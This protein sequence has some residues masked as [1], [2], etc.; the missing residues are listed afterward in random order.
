MSQKHPWER[1]FHILS[2]PVDTCRDYLLNKQ[3][4]REE[5]GGERK[6]EKTERE[7]EGVRERGGRGE[8]KIEREKM[9]K[10]QKGGVRGRGREGRKR[11]REG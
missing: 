4:G 8:R 10:E 7:R 1:L 2:N 3:P 5:R 9:E 6:I 11:G